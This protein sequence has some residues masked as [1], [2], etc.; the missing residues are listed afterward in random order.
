ME[1][2]HECKKNC[3]A[4]FTALVVIAGILT[5][6]FYNNEDLRFWE[7]SDKIKCPKLFGKDF[8]K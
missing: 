7:E 3:C 6:T 4:I 8:D 5:W 1:R 2:K